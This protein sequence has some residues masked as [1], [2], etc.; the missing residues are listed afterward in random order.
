MVRKKRGRAKILASIVVG[1][2]H[3]DESGK[4]IQAR[5]VFVRD[6]NRSKQWLALLTTNLEHTE[7]DAIRIYG[8]R[9]EVECFSKVVKSNLRLAK[10]F[11][12]RSY[13]FMTAH[14]TIVFLRYMMLSLSVR[15]EEDPRTIGQLFYLCCDE[16]EDIRFAEVLMM[17]LD[18]ISSTMAEEYLLTDEQI[19]QFFDRFF[20]KLPGF[21]KNSLLHT[22]IPDS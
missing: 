4:E 12:C 3:D 6:R 5:I 11:Q 18:I 20:S 8:K 22:R 13:D 7:E 16:M 19:N 10:E 21:L 2:R 15:E 9:W 17:I 14:T 1:L